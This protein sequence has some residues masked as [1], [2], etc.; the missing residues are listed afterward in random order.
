MRLS[1]TE[2][3]CMHIWKHHK[4]PLL[5]A[6][7]IHYYTE[8]TPETS[9]FP[10]PLRR[11]L[12]HMKELQALGASISCGLW[13]LWVA[14]LPWALAGA[15][16]PPVAPC[17]S[18]PRLPGVSDWMELGLVD[19]RNDRMV[20]TDFPCYPSLPLPGVR[21]GRGWGGS[22]TLFSFT[23]LH[24]C[25]WVSCRPFSSISSQASLKSSICK[26][27]QEQIP[28]ACPPSPDSHPSV[29]WEAVINN[30]WETVW[31]AA[32]SLLLPLTIT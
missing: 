14:P 4:K 24:S 22:C 12:S 20:P 9:N 16:V 2:A 1:T 21:R 6:T 23:V 32:P 5:C 18:A 11:L 25:C 10:F 28:A 13:W 3:P 31:S 8:Q 7:N 19:G 26:P 30:G 29:G 15:Q 27:S 17:S